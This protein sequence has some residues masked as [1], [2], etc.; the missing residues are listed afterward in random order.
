MFRKVKILKKWGEEG[1]GMNTKKIIIIYIYTYIKV[2]K[3]AEKKNKQ[4]TKTRPVLSKG[5]IQ[6]SYQQDVYKRV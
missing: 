5:D 1:K 6:I 3:R 2:L 4:H